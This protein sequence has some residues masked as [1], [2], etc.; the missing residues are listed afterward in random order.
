MIS[1][2]NEVMSL[3]NL[4]KMVFR[5]D[6]ASKMHDKLP[7]LLFQMKNFELLHNHKK[8][9]YS[10]FM[11]PYC[12]LLSFLS[13]DLTFEKRILFLNMARI[14]LKKTTFHITSI[15]FLIKYI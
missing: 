12:L 15:I 1:N 6:R 10:I 11:L 5:K 8:Y 4:P 2:K 3:L 9:N 14:L 7:L 13:Y